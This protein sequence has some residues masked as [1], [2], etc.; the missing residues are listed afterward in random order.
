[1]HI[2][3][4]PCVLLLIIMGAFIQ[5]FY[6]LFHAARSALQS[7][8][9]RQTQRY[10]RVHSQL[11]GKYTSLQSVRCSMLSILR[12]S[13]TLHS[14]VL[15]R[16][17]Y[18]LWYT[19]NRHKDYYYHCLICCDPYYFNKRLCWAVYSYYI[20]IFYF[21]YR[22]EQIYVITLV[23]F[24]KFSTNIN[25]RLIFFFGS[26]LFLTTLYPG[27]NIFFLTYPFCYHLVPVS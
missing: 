14:R 3:Q 20:S 11:H 10:T 17:G 9:P 13:F 7:L 22:Y 12:I 18:N 23:F 19:C 1:M 26:T 24:S 16:P 8:L 15:I 21:L 25:C 4:I 27:T 5:R 6:Q 2:V